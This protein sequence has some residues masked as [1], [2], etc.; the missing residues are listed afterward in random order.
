MGRHA[1]AYTLRHAISTETAG[2]KCDGIHDGI[3]EWVDPG[4][5]PAGTPI[6]KIRKAGRRVT[7]ESSLDGGAT[8]YLE[9]ARTPM[10]TGSF[11]KKYALLV[12]T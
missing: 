4:R 1:L 10:T 12:T 3:I 6:R 11:Y 8:W 9:R 7:F 2:T 5:L